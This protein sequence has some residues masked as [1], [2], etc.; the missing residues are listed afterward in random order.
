MIL[1][2]SEILFLIDRGVLK[3]PKEAV[4]PSSVD[5]TLAKGFMIER[6][7]VPGI[8]SLVDLKHERPM[9][10]KIDSASLIIEPGM[11]VLGSIRERLNLP[12]DITAEL[13]LTNTEARCGI[14]HALAV[15]AD[16]GFRGNLTVELTNTLRH[17]SIL[18]Y[19][20]M[21]IGQLLFHRHKPSLKPYHGRYQGDIAV[22]EGK[23]KVRQAK[24]ILDDEIETRRRF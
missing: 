16:C 7:P 8:V 6:W 21:R 15:W 1:E 9:M 10:E 2:H 3:A 19:E 5:V 23:E 11:F 17:H 4:G 20:G 22:S 14:Q 13:R 12:P 18:L 24:R